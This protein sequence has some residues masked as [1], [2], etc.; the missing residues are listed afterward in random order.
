MIYQSNFPRKPFS[1]EYVAEMV[2]LYNTE[3]MY[4][5]N[6]DDKKLEPQIHEDVLSVGFVYDKEQDLYGIK[7]KD[8]DVYFTLEHPN[9]WLNLSINQIYWQLNHY[10]KGGNSVDSIDWEWVHCQVTQ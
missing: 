3:W 4:T 10:C 2:N 5:D 6:D 1:K 7:V 9:G 8:K